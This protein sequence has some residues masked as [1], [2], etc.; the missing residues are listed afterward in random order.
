MKTVAFLPVK[1]S[2]SRVKNKNIRP[3]NGEPLFVFTLRKLLRC[4]FIDE[5]YLDSESDEILSIGKRLGAHLLKRDPSLADNRTDGNKL[6]MNEINHVEAD[7]YIQHLCTSPFVKESTIRAAVNK[8]DDSAE[9]DSV[10]LGR[11]EKVYPWMGNKP[12]YDINHIPNSVDLPPSRSEA[13][14]L[15]VIRR[16]AAFQTGRRVGNLPYFLN[17]EPIELIDINNESDLDLAN[18]VGAGLLAQEEKRLK[19]IG[20]VLTSPV[21]SDVMDDLGLSGVLA[22]GYECNLPETKAFGRARTLHL[23]SATPDDPPD[24]IYKALRSYLQ[25]VSN[26]IIVVKNDQPSLAYFGELNMSLAIRSG[27]VG[28]VI[29]GVT[30]DT[31]PTK[32]AGFPVYAKGRHCRD[33]KGKGAVQTM[34]QPI[35]IDGV[36]VHPSDLIFCDR[37]GIVVIPRTHE[38]EVLHRALEIVQREKEIVRDICSDID[39]NNIVSKY[40]FF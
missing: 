17:G 34:N 32:T 7:I 35:E 14:A 12:A 23:R 2:S 16:E 5:V 13:M 36:T 37:D 22:P 30:R 15:Y 24:S 21:L 10:V 8:L 11:E 29:A 26:D 25:V 6:F 18:L 27:A 28:A 31:G 9:Y 3:F 39:I 1:G 38:A 40:G 20:R 4:D 19:L 33:I